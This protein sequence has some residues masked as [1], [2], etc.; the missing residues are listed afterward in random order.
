MP[1]MV[2]FLI[3]G[4]KF[5]M[6]VMAKDF[7]A[8]PFLIFLRWIK[9]DRIVLDFIIACS[10]QSHSFDKLCRVLKR[11]KVHHHHH[12]LS[13]IAP[14]LLELLTVNCRRTL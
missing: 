14:H 5:F 9:W 10:C 3:L 13:H 1:V 6:T 12:S 7:F 4:N 2:P 11:V 8:K